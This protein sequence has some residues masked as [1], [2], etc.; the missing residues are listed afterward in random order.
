MVDADDRDWCALLRRIYYAESSLKLLPLRCLPALL[1]DVRLSGQECLGVLVGRSTG[2][3]LAHDREIE[4]MFLDLLS[5][6]R[7]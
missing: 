7:R 3:S 1:A 6:I 4:L 5:K 2:W